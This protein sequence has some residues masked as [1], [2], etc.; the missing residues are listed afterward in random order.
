MDLKTPPSIGKNASIRP[1]RVSQPRLL[2]SKVKK[3]KNLSG[4]KTQTIINKN[5]SNNVQVRNPLD[6][7]TRAD[8]LALLRNR[9]KVAKGLPMNW[10][11]LVTARCFEIEPFALWSKV[12][13]FLGLI[14]LWTRTWGEAYTLKRRKEIFTA[15]VSFFTRSRSPLVYTSRMALNRRGLPRTAGLNLI[16]GR[17]PDDNKIRCVLSILKLYDL[18]RLPVSDSVDSIILP[19][20]RPLDLSWISTDLSVVLREKKKTFSPNHQILW[21]VSEKGGPNG[22]PGFLKYRQDAVAV[23]K[24]DEVFGHIKRVSDLTGRFWIREELEKIGT[25]CSHYS[26]PGLCHSRL[27]ALQDKAGKTRVVAMVDVYTQTC[28]KPLHD[29]FLEILSRFPPDCTSNQDRGRDKI[30]EISRQGRMM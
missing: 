26:D 28:L 9:F 10:F 6:V 15:Y 4:S 14:N 12:I 27:S 17:A 18:V 11:V 8:F 29:Y 1:I 5:K 25:G 2:N 16:L 13:P 7:A 23:L 22:S 30:K 20:T 19:I 3:T 24:D 21:F